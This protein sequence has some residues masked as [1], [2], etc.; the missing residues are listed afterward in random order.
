MIAF[1]DLFKKDVL[2]KVLLF[3]NVFS[4]TATINN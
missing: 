4:S 3:S 1:I 2:F